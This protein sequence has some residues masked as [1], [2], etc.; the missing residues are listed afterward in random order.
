MQD[1]LVHPA[2]QSAAA[3]LMVSLMMAVMLWRASARWQ[4]LAILAGF[5][6]AMVLIT[7]FSLLPLTSTRKIILASLGLPLLALASEFMLKRPSVRMIVLTIIAAAAMPWIIWP[8]LSRMEMGEAL[9]LMA[10][11]MLYVAWSVVIFIAWENSPE[12]IGSAALAMA[13]GTGGAAMIGASALY[14]QLGFAVAA[15][16]GGLLLRWMI[17]PGRN[18][19]GLAAAIAVAA[20]LALIGAAATVYAKLPWTALPWLALIP[21][22]ARIPVAPRSSRWLRVPLMTVISMLPAIPALWLAWRAAGDVVY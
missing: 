12:R 8:V 22:A 14:G 20:P 9:P 4:G 19:F 1:L 15:A 5:L 11:L 2:V 18:G 16:M 21:L 3:P 7:G 13:T 10:G 6:T 17:A